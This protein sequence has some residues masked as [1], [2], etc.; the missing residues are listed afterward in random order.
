M[1]EAI[2]YLQKKEG[3][4]ILEAI[5]FELF[6]LNQADSDSPKEQELQKQLIE[7]LQSQ[8]NV[9]QVLDLLSVL[10]E[11]LN[12]KEFY[13]WLREL[14]GNTLSAGVSRLID[15][16]LPDVG[17]G[18]INVDHKWTGDSLTI[19]ATESESGGVGVIQRFKRTYL[20]DPLSVLNHFSRTFEAQD[21]EQVDFD[22]RFLLSTRKATQ[23]AFNDLRNARS[24]KQ[25]FEANLQIQKV[26]GNMGVTTTQTLNNM[27]HTRVL[28]SGSNEQTDEYLNKLLGTWVRMEEEHKVEIPLNIASYLLA[29]SKASSG[30]NISVVKNK[31]LSLLWP[32]GSVIRQSGLSFY[33]RFVSGKSKTERLLLE[34]VIGE[35]CPIIAYALG[36]E[37]ELVDNLKASGKV[38][39]ELEQYDIK[40]V[41]HAISRILTL[42]VEQYGLLLYPRLRRI[43]RQFGKV[44]LIVEIAE[45][46]Q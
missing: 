42:P 43:R 16:L 34:P 44:Q 18:D 35:K 46:V 40:Q 23:S 7:F 19:W 21:Y 31:I 26:L 17:D 22:L 39:L 41:N 8:A 3:R 6:Q 11:P 28:R 5:P 36:W 24:Y 32:R 38:V 9:S 33:N 27:L 20:E 10:H 14:L 13:L 12:S 15:T 30:E 29:R 25:R 45:V 4:A 1:S 37:R 2:N